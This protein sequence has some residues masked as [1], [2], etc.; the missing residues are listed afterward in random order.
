[1]RICVVPVLVPTTENAMVDL[2]VY[3]YTGV[4]IDYEY[5]Y[6]TEL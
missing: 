4:V 5:Q 1:M 2:V 3:Y 6:R